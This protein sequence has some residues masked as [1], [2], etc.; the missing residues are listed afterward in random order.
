M[1][2]DEQD[3]ILV[4]CVDRQGDGHAR[5]HHRVLERYEQQV[6]QNNTLQSVY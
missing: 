5:E 4:A 6:T 1:L 2:R 3:A